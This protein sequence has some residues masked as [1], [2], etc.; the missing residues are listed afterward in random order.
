MKFYNF[1][2]HI[3]VLYETIFALFVVLHVE[4]SEP[5]TRRDATLHMIVF[6]LCTFWGS[7]VITWLLW[8]QTYAAA[9]M[10]LTEI[11]RNL[12]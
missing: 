2:R 12:T 5:E 8:G 11:R 10:R 6:V 3:G 1:V 7:A 4:S 9:G